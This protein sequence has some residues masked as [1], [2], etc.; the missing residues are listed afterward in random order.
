MESNYFETEPLV[1]RGQGA[2]E[3]KTFPL[4]PNWINTIDELMAIAATVRIAA[5]RNFGRTGLTV[6]TPRAVTAA[7]NDQKTTTPIV[8]PHDGIWNGRNP[9]DRLRR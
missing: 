6:R 8:Y 2:P 1:E 3:K 4:K 5:T 9:T 7:V